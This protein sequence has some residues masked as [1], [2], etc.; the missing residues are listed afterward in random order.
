MM[1]EI[2][3]PDHVIAACNMTGCHEG[4]DAIKDGLAKGIMWPALFKALLE[5][6]LPAFIEWVKHWGEASEPVP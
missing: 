5:M 1:K 4:S 2:L 6:A 3:N